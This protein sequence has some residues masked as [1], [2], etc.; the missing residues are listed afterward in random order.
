MPVNSTDPLPPSLDGLPP[1]STTSPSEPAPTLSSDSGHPADAQKCS[2]SH[3]QLEQTPR[4]E[5][6]STGHHGP[7]D[8][9]PKPWTEGVTTAAE[10]AMAAQIRTGTTNW[11]ANSLQC[12]PSDLLHHT[13]C[14]SCRAGSDGSLNAL[15][16]G[17][18]R[19]E[20]SSPTITRTGQSIDS[21]P[22][23]IPTRSETSREDPVASHAHLRPEVQLQEWQVVLNK[24]RDLGKNRRMGEAPDFATIISCYSAIVGGGPKDFPVREPEIAS[25]VSQAS[26]AM[27]ACKNIARRLKISRPSRGL[28]Q[29]APNSNHGLSL[30]PPSRKTSDAMVKLYFEFFESTHRILHNP[31]FWVDY[32]RYWHQPETVTNDLRFKVLLVIAIGSSLYDH[33]DST[34]TFEHMETIRPWIY[35]AE[36]WL[37]GPLEK[38]RLDIGGIQIYCLSIIARQIFSIGGDLVWMSMGSLIHR[39]MQIGLHRDPKHLP[40]VSVLQSEIRRRLWATILDLVVQAS[41]DAWMPPR[42]SFD[43]FDTE[44]PSNINDDG[45]DEST[46]E[47][48]PIPRATFTN[49]STQLALLDSFPVRLRIVQVLNGLHSDLSYSDVLIISSELTKALRKSSNISMTRLDDQGGTMLSMRPFHRSLLDYLVRRFMI[50]LHYYFSNQTHFDPLFHYSLKLSVDSALALVSPEPDPCG[51]FAR[52]MAMGGGLF[53]EGLRC[54][55]T[56]ISLELLA[57]ISAQQQSGTLHRTPQHRQLLKDAIRDLIALSEERI[58]IGETNIKSYMFLSMVLAQVEAVEVGIDIHLAVAKSAAD[59]LRFSLGILSERAQAFSTPEN[60]DNMSAFDGTAGAVSSDMDLDN[61]WLNW[62]WGAVSPNTSFL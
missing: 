38:D 45:M 7:R 50:P 6:S 12:P 36:A 44:P 28:T 19:L 41:L 42:I 1:A 37:A 22:S 59:S 54:A 33:G 13:D 58:R 9:Q 60:S 20:G 4:P 35:A 27:L 21:I 8:G 52:L 24:P 43:E 18:Q 62:D 16:Q 32:Q 25:L 26:E 57:H 10:M 23:S 55:I 3:E 29:V 14:L 15:L 31:T 30:V 48:T 5:A 51:L 17:V 40:D 53:R 56:A 46:T 39:A 2:Q 61:Y 34:A 11:E 49:T 47:I